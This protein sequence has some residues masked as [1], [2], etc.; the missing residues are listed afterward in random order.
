MTYND[1]Q[2]ATTIYN[3]LQQ[4]TTIYNELQRPIQTTFLWS[5]RVEPRPVSKQVTV[6]SMNYHLYFTCL[7]TKPFQQTTS[8]MYVIDKNKYK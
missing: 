2:Q 7:V 4:V 1:L 5:E 3:D 6:D 8:P